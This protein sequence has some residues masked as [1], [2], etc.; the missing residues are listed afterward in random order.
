[1]YCIWNADSN[2]NFWSGH[3]FIYLKLSYA[4]GILL[5][6][7]ALH[8]ICVSL[9][10]GSKGKPM[11]FCSNTTSYLC[12]FSK[13]VKGD[14]APHA[15]SVKLRAKRSQITFEAVQKVICYPLECIDKSKKTT[16]F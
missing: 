6:Y 3:N 13:V 11:T 7:S 15:N 14:G 5:T 8:V 4:S 12:S 2:R 10:K 1:M 9:A 16:F